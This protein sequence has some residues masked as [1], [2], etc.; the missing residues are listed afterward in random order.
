MI[1][2]PAIE[3]DSIDPKTA[4]LDHDK[5]WCVIS[6]RQHSA[7]ASN[8]LG[9][10]GRQGTAEDV[11]NGS[12][13]DADN[14]IWAVVSVVQEIGVCELV[15]WIEGSIEGQDRRLGCTKWGEEFC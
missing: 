4:R 14:R 15:P 10:D 5:E 9:F 11:G 6:L 2:R 8:S 13:L 3:I 7:E 1:N 12:I